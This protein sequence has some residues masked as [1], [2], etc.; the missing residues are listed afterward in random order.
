VLPAYRARIGVALLSTALV[1]AAPLRAQIPSVQRVVSSDPGIDRANVVG[2]WE[3]AGATAAVGA[4]LAVDRPVHVFFQE[5]RTKETD[6][7]AAVFRRFGTPPVFGAVSVGVLGAGFVSGD[8][9]VRRAGGRLVASF[10]LSV[11]SVEILKKLVGRARPDEDA[12]AFTFHPF[13]RKQTSFPS[14]HTASAF[15]LAT[16]LAEDIESPWASVPLYLIA[17][18]TAWSRLNDDRHWPSDVA[19]GAL[20]GITT[21]K[22]VS[23]HWLMFGIRSPDWLRDPDVVP[24]ER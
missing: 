11:A 9:D 7:V 3:A 20:L 19:A 15:A 2:G 17:S 16:S 6:A 18:G 22:V 21:A 10:V 24:P 23:G 5:H 13:T 1:S 12:G 8:R 4:L 14:G